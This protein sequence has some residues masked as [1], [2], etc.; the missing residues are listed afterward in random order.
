MWTA[1]QQTIHRRE[2]E[3]FSSNLTNAEWAHPAELDQLVEVGRDVDVHGVVRWRCID[4][5]VV[6]Q[7]RFGVSTGLGISL[8]VGA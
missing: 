1:E 3:R 2:S 4:L 8:L 5:T 6:I 7:E